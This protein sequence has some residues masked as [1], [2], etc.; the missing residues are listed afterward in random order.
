MMHDHSALNAGHKIAVQY[1]AGCQ[2]GR[3]QDIR[4]QY[5][6][7]Q[8]ARCRADVRRKL[9]GSLMNVRWTSDGSRTHVRQKSDGTQ[10]SRA[11]PPL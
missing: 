5:V 4:A 1:Y 6:G 10:T 3:A 9:D 11:Q 7:H 8:G 2:G